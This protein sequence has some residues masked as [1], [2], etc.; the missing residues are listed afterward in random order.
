MRQRRAEKQIQEAKPTK[1][2]P[3]QIQ[4]HQQITKIIEVLDGTQHLIQKPNQPTNQRN[5]S[6]N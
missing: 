4:I 1:R 5:K 3:M 2:R 6:K